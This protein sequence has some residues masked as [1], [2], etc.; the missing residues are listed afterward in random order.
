MAQLFRP[1]PRGIGQLART[2]AMQ[3]ALVPTARAIAEAG[4][5]LAP[6]SNDGVEPTLSR[7]HTVVRGIPGRNRT[8]VWVVA[9]TPYAGR[10]VARNN[11]LQ[12][13]IDSVTPNSG[14]RAADLRVAKKEARKPRRP[15]RD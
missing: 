12:R 10:V 11:Y 4:N 3:E 1:N 7:S 13:A 6:V 2:A 8:R 14:P 9:D 5:R 15:A